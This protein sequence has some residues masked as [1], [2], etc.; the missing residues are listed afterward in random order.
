MS[1]RSSYACV[2]AEQPTRVAIFRALQARRTF[3]A[4]DKIWL[5]VLADDQWMG[6]IYQ[7]D[8]APRLTLRA[9]GTAPFRSIDLV[10]D[11]KIHKTYSPDGM[12]VDI[13]ETLELTGR[14]YV[15]FHLQQR[16]DNQAWSSPIW[17]NTHE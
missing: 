8:H 9:R 3:A 15:Y 13:D 1:T 2:W 12:D 6:E 16:D 14:H 5:A 17:I 7:A 10:V 11:G 4:T